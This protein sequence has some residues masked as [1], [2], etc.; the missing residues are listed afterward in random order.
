MQTPF[1]HHPPDFPWI[2]QRPAQ[3]PSPRPKRSQITRGWRIWSPVGL[4]STKIKDFVN[5]LLMP[6][7]IRWN[8]WKLMLPG[9]E[10]TLKMIVIV[11]RR[12]IARNFDMM[13]YCFLWICKLVFFRWTEWW[14]L[15]NL[16]LYTKVQPRKYDTLP[17]S[18]LQP[19]TK[20]VNGYGTWCSVNRI[21]LSGFE[22]FQI[23]MT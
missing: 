15:P 12:E 14:G 6:E 23:K 20:H 2:I 3:A 13:H 22:F 19:I 18:Y 9:V 5:S 16:G 21:F 11:I 8:Y 1:S 17:E 4:A 7:L 10:V